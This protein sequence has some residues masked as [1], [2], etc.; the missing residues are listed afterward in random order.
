MSNKK[1]I[2]IK[3]GEIKVRKP[4]APATISFKNKKGKGSYNRKK[5]KKDDLVL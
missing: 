4:S 1:K 5:F 2:V 3:L